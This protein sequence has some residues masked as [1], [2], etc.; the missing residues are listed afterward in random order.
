MNRKFERQYK[1]ALRR[2]VLGQLHNTFLHY[3]VPIF[4]LFVFVD[5]YLTGAF[6]PF[7]IGRGIITLVS[8]G[9]ILVSK[10]KR[11]VIAR[12]Y[13]VIPCLLF[14][15]YNAFICL[16]MYYFPEKLKMYFA[17]LIVVSSGMT[18]VFVNVDRQIFVASIG[19]LVAYGLVL[20]L[21]FDFYQENYT[22]LIIS[23][24]FLI[25][26]CIVNIIGSR[27]VAVVRKKGFQDKYKLRY[28]R[29][30]RDQIIRSKAKELA[31]TE[32][33]NSQ[34]SPQISKMF[35]EGTL[36]TEEF[37][38]DIISVLVIDVVDSTKKLYELESKSAY[39]AIERT[40]D[41]IANT[42]LE[43]DI[44]VDKFTGDGVMAL[45]NAPV[46]YENHLEKCF[47]AC[48]E[49]NARI[50]ENN[51]ILSAHWGGPMQLRYSIHTGEAIYGFIGRGRVKSFTALG[52]SVNL[53]HRINGHAPINGLIVSSDS[54]VDKEFFIKKLDL[55]EVDS[56]KVLCKG[57]EKMIEVSSFSFLSNKNNIR[58]VNNEIICECGNE[59]ILK[60]SKHGKYELVCESCNHNTD[61]IK[62]AA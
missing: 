9:L 2:E 12:L 41:I 29:I 10:I 45:S 51:I 34:F 38:S 22:F 8:I 53:A 16:S 28:E 17:G 14:F 61:D 11:N 21:H 48:I 1:L 30:R 59:L 36:N 60:A 19:T 42:L 35:K 46:K 54:I 55:Q 56:T 5:Y 27:S 33:L 13:N 58:K 4:F 7:F 52:K 3:A 32:L 24:S 20:F 62:K 18:A 23:S 37:E 43:Y 31:S 49:I 50:E 57:F 39:V 47:Q 15:S 44:T 26:S 6:S 40:F 25:T